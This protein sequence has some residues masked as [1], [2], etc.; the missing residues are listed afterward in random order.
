MFCLDV[1]PEVLAAGDQIK[2]SIKLWIF[3]EYFLTFGV[4]KVHNLAEYMAF[5]VTF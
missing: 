4:I 5:Y 1:S 3:Q 2:S